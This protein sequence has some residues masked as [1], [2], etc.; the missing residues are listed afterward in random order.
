MKT[1]DEYYLADPLPSG[2]GLTPEQAARVLGGEACMWA[3]HVDATTVDS[4]IWPRMAAIAE[5]FWSP[6]SVRDVDDMYRRLSL[7]SIQLERE[8][9]THE[10]HTY[11]MLRLLAGRRGVQPLHDLL[12]A[13]MPATFSQRSRLQGPTQLIPLTR[14]VDA[15]RPDPWARSRL[16]RL[17]AEVVS[18]PGEASAAREELARTFA[19]WAPL[20]AQVA[21]LTDSV[22][23]AR[24]G[25][26]AARALGR[27]A[28]V[29]IAALGHL[30]NGRPPAEWRETAR[31]ALDELANPHG[32]LR[33]AGVESV[34]LLVEAV[35]AA[36]PAS[37]GR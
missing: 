14:L 16:M 37:G 29:G 15:A 27:L 1:T 25:D 13:T 21:A 28:E 8:G 33:L 7:V 36:V 32:L 4:R 34:R 5:R 18:R 24:D 2:H 20:G 11:R 30:A 22:P 23:L 6:A 19:S 3:E 9:L 35:P 12:A 26:P 17:A 31:T 10:A